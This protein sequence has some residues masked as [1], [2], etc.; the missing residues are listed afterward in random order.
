VAGTTSLT[1]KHKTKLNKSY[2]NILAAQKQKG[3]QELASK[4]TK[5]HLSSSPRRASSSGKK[6]GMCSKNISKKK[7][8]NEGASTRGLTNNGKTFYNMKDLNFFIKTIEKDL[9][10]KFNKMNLKDFNSMPTTPTSILKK[11]ED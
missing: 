7:Y 9:S 4:S 1:S 2:E 3:A 8:T 6:S 5:K 11:V 10:E